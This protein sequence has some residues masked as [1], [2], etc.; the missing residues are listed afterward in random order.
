MVSGA[1]QEGCPCYTFEHGCCPDGITKA[2]GHNLEGCAD[3]STS[4]FGCCPD[5]FTPAGENGCGCEGSEFGCCPDGLTPAEGADFEGCNEIPGQYCDV[6]KNTGTCN[7]QNSQNFTIKWFFD[8][9]YGGCSRFWFANCASDE[10]HAS[11][12]SIIGPLNESFKGNENL[13]GDDKSMPLHEVE[14]V[15]LV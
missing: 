3:C 11:I 4:E 12:P 7:K 9:E 2:Q 10:E 8:L 6:P 13:C 15:E 14:L 5:N 1:N